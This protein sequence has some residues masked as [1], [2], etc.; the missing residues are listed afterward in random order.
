[1][2]QSHM[3]HIAHSI[4][5]LKVKVVKVLVIVGDIHGETK[6]NEEN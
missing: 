4:I 6:R 1:M 3:T 2:N 5:N